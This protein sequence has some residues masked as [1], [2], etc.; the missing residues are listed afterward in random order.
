MTENEAAELYI[1]LTDAIGYRPGK[2]LLSPEE[3]GRMLAADRKVSVTQLIQQAVNEVTR[4]ENLSDSQWEYVKAGVRLLVTSVNQMLSNIREDQSPTPG[5]ALARYRAA[6]DGEHEVDPIERLRFY[7]S[8]AMGAQDWL[9]SEPFFDDLASCQGEGNQMQGAEIAQ[10][11]AALNEA[12][13]VLESAR[14]LCNWPSMNEAID[15][16]ARAGRAA[17]AQEQGGSDDNR[18]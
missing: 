5:Y 4:P 3:W 13:R 1:R 8:L 10:M 2:Q 11:R 7:C 17:L 14:L 9:D 16:A 15:A 6:M 12:V 18:D